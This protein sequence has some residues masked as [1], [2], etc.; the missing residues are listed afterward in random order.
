MLGI[1]HDFQHSQG[2]DL[3]DK[4]GPCTSRSAAHRA[5]ITL[6]HFFK[7]TELDDCL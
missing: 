4:L 6:I 2:H 3:H 5:V 1:V 7:S